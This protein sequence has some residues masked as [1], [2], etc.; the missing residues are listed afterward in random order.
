MHLYELH[1]TSQQTPHHIDHLKEKLRQ[2]SFS[3]I[4]L[5]SQGECTHAFRYLLST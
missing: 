2:Y 5:D 3:L 4:A 1:S